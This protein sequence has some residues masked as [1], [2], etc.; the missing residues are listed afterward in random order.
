MVSCYS[1][2]NIVS[3][4]L[5]YA[6]SYSPVDAGVIGVSVSVVIVTIAGGGGGIV[7]IIVV[8]KW[9]NKKKKEVGGY[10]RLNHT[11]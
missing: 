9:R 6:F 2:N 8:I 3:S 7:V 5:S 1:L 11:L 4:H 10:R